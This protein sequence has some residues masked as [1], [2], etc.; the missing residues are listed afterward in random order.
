[1]AKYKSG[2]YTPKSG[3]YAGTSFPSYRQYLNARARDVGFPSF[4]AQGRAGATTSQVA[5]AG[6]SKA[7]KD[8]YGYAL[9]VL[10]RMRRNGET[11]TQAAAAERI[12]PSIVRKHANRYLI[13]RNGE[14]YATNR[15]RLIRPMIVLTPV[16]PMDIFIKDSRTASLNGAYWNAV[17][18][19]RDTGDDSGL[20]QF[21]GKGITSNGV[22]Y[23]FI[24]NTDLIDQL[25]DA[26]GLDVSE[27][28]SLSR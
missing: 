14:I 4:S 13:N 26:G 16:G 24:T 28:Y 1:M 5:I 6:L 22:Y 7:E 15:D 3:K 19:Y 12:D 17:L 18:T 10:R 20:K 25:G 27:I 8:E 23:P 2:V 21:K 11:L 9:G